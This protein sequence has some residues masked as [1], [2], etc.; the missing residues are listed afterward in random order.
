M[1]A[2]DANDNI[3]DVTRREHDLLA[4]AERLTHE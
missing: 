4:A 3:R 2:I 1:L